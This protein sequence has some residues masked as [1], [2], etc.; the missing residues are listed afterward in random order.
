MRKTLVLALCALL[1]GC[2]DGGS[3]ADRARNDHDLTAFG[4]AGLA[5]TSQVRTDSNNV[6]DILHRAG[7]K[8]P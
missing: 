3:A 6:D 5:L 7:A 8:D 2:A 1:A 4:G